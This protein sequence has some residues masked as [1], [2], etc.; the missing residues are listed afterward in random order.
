MKDI[1][2]LNFFEIIVIWINEYFW[3]GFRAFATC[4]SYLTLLVCKRQRGKNKL[5]GNK[6][7]LERMCDRLGISSANPPISPFGQII[8]K[9]IVSFKLWSVFVKILFLFGFVLKDFKANQEREVNCTWKTTSDVSKITRALY[10][11]LHIGTY[12]SLISRYTETGEEDVCHFNF[13]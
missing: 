13:M 4:K 11:A 8:K 1:K 6:D 3:Y 2:A 5:K 9:H 10:R 7:G 12:T